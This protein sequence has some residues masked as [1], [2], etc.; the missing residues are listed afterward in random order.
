[1]HPALNEDRRHPEVP[2]GQCSAVYVW[3]YPIRLFHWALVFSIAV[4]AVTGYYIHDPFI[5]DQVKRP[6]LMGWFRFVHESFGMIFI[7]LFVMRI[8]L[9][10][11]FSGGDRWVRWDQYIPLRGVQFRE[12]LNVMEFYLF[13]RRTPI[14]K[15][16]HNGMAALSYVAVYTL[17][18]VEIVTGLVMYDWIMQSPVIHFLVGWIPR[19]VDIQN[20]RLIHFFAMYLFVIFGIFHVHIAML[21]SRVEKRGLMDSMFTGYKVIPVTELDEAEKQAELSRK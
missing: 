8:C 2:V 18:L 5:I 3:Q 4:L 12:M 6:Y 19:V 14:S 9:F 15:I 20:I 17:M 10:F 16:G 13:I 7:A 1:M 21:I 11:R